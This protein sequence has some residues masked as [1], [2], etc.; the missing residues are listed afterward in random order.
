MFLDIFADCQY[1]LLTRGVTVTNKV[2]Y[3]AFDWLQC[4]MNFTIWCATAGWG[5][6]AEDHLQHKESLLASL[7]ISRLFYDSGHSDWAKNLPFQGTSPILGT[8]TIFM[9]GTASGFAM[10]LVCHQPPTGGRRWIM[11]VKASALT[12]SLW[13][14]PVSIGMNTVHSVHSLI[15]RPNQAQLWHFRSLNIIY[16]SQIRW[17]HGVGVYMTRTALMFGQFW[18]GKLRHVLTFSTPERDWMPK[19]YSRQLLKTRLH[20]R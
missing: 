11:D 12:V 8:R 13:H 6:Y 1:P 18:E 7:S 3:T 4:Q 20:H 17:F 15:Q 5:V 2:W 10:S 9:P 16:S 14:R 19:H